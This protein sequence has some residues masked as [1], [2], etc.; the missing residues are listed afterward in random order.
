MARPTAC[1][2][3]AWPKPVETKIAS[4]T[5]IWAVEGALLLGIVWCS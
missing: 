3:P 5:A 2:C 4:V 1:R